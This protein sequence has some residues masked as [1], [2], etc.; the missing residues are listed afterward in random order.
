ML[1]TWSR[2]ECETKMWSILRQRLEGE[3]AHAGAGVD[4]H[5]V[6][7]EQRRGAQ[8]SADPSAATQNPDLH[9]VTSPRGG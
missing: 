5:V 2:C 1:V 8:A 9:F 4:Q 6:V 3:V 7:H